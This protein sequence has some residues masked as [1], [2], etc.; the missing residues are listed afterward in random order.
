MQNDDPIKESNIE[1]LEFISQFDGSLLY[2]RNAF[3]LLQ[4]P[5]TATDRDI[6]RRKQIFEISKKTQAPIP[7]GSC[8]LFPI[9]LS[10]DHMDIHQLVESLR[11]PILRFYQEFFWFWPLNDSKSVDDPALHAISEGDIDQ[12]LKIWAKPNSNPKV[13]TVQ[14]H[15]LAVYSHFQALENIADKSEPDSIQYWETAYLRWGDLVASSDFWSLLDNRVREI[16]DPR[17]RIGHVKTLRRAITKIIA[18]T[19][20]TEAARLAENKDFEGASSLLSPFHNNFAD[21]Q[22]GF[23]ILKLAT[24]PYRER[25]RVA[26]SLAENKAENDPAHADVAAEALLLEGGKQLG[27]IS[28]LLSENEVSVI[29]LR[30]DILD[31]AIQAIDTFFDKTDDWERAIDLFI[32]AKPFAVQSKEKTKI[33]ERLKG[34]KEFGSNQNYWCCKG[35]FNNE[36]P[37][38]LFAKLEEARQSF[39]HQDYD[40]TIRLLESALITFESVSEVSKKAIHPP[41]AMTLNRKARG[42][43]EK[44]INYFESPRPIMQKIQQNVRTRSYRCGYSIMAIQRDMIDYA[45][46]QDQLYCMACESRINDNFY[47]GKL[48]DNKVILCSSC[49]Y[50]DDKDRD[51]MKNQAYNYLNKAKDVLQRAFALQPNNVFVIKNLD[52][53]KEIFWDVYKINITEPSKVKASTVSPPTKSPTNKTLNSDVSNDIDPW[54][55]LGA[56]FAILILLVL[57]A[58]IYSY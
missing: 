57:C 47:I 56:T 24:D 31:K 46:R 25:L 11:D 27:V 51:S 33:Q 26:A 32:K 1:D 30:E 5:V 14:L 9:D 21:N 44:G 49:N 22:N 40:T 39:D 7:D 2:K 53:L 12:A 55:I 34:L 29:S 45:A 58:Y 4:L 20:V 52:F 28:S 41:L 42:L 38:T 6:T 13:N 23:E 3:R 18:F 35:Y 15:N 54:K 50:Q 37:P 8:K 19:N 10:E 48:N 17:L 16:D 36:I 43:I